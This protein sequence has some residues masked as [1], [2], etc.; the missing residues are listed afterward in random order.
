MVISSC[1]NIV[2]IKN[3]NALSGLKFALCSYVYLVIW[4]KCFGD[5]WVALSIKILQLITSNAYNFSFFIFFLFFW[6][7]V[8]LNRD[9]FVLCNVFFYT[10]L[11][12]EV[13][14]AVLVSITISLIFYILYNRTKRPNFSDSCLV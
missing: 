13:G 12:K 1:Q 4:V 2:D 3:K 11:D 5:I 10:S 8:Y 7:K 6:V 14:N 9:I